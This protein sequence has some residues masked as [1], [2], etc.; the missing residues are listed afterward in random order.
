VKLK[1]GGHRFVSIKYILCPEKKEQN[2]FHDISYKAWT[3]LSRWKMF[4]W[5]CSKFNQE[6]VYQ[7]RNFVRIARVL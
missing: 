4:T 6:M 1:T 3:M 2:V 5:F 7:S